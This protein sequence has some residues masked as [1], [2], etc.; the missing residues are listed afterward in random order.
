MNQ[1]MTMNKML[2]KLDNAHADIRRHEDELRRLG[3]ECAPMVHGHPSIRRRIKNDLQPQ[4]NKLN[5]EIRSL[6][7]ANGATSSA[8]LERHALHEMQ[9]QIGQ[10]D[11]IVLNSDRRRYGDNFPQTGGSGFVWTGIFE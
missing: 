2:I 7:E 5:Q 10:G 6:K 9:K 8:G 1:S 4:I 11:R 3:R